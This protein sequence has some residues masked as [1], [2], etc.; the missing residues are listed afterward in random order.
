M[1]NTRPTREAETRA[2]EIMETYNMNYVS[3]LEIPASN[4]ASVSRLRSVIFSKNMLCIIVIV[5]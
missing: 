5:L 4:K 3:G 2:N 1:K